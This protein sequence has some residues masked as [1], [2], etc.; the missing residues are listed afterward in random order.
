VARTELH[1]SRLPR[2]YLKSPLY[3]TRPIVTPRAT[4]VQRLEVEIGGALANLVTVIIPFF[5]GFAEVESN[6]DA[7]IRILDRRLGEAGIC[8]EHW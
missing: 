3:S 1:Y 5:S 7:R 8:A 4:S 2:T 6:E